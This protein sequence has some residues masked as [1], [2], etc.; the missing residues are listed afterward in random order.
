MEKRLKYLLEKKNLSYDEME[1][2]KNL[3]PV[4]SWKIIGNWKRIGSTP[5]FKK[6]AINFQTIGKRIQ[7]A[8]NSRCYIEVISLRLLLIDVALRL[9]LNSK[10]EKFINKKPKELQFGSLLQKI[11]KHNFD[12]DLLKRLKDFNKKR[13]EAIH[14]FLYR[15]IEY[16]SFFVFIIK[17]DNLATD[18]WNYCTN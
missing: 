2:F 9:F 1:E 3:A 12:A 16:D 14:N 4:N 15:G 5:N 10:G 11:E 18:V 17:T 8:I 13:I 6:V 7:H